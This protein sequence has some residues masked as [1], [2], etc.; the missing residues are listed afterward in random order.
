MRD[1]PFGICT[2]KNG[3]CLTTKMIWLCLKM[4]LYPATHGIFWLNCGKRWSVDGF[5]VFPRVFQKCSGC[6]TP[7]GWGVCFWLYFPMSWGWSLVPYLG[8]KID[9]EF[10]DILFF[11][12]FSGDQNGETLTGTSEDL[13][14]SNPPYIPT[15]SEAAGKLSP[16]SGGSSWRFSGVKGGSLGNPWTKVL[17]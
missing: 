5:F 8:T 14:V 13:I 16:H 4:E 9:T 17:V 1:L 12:F 6:S 2:C 11:L 15:K 3:I 7:L 10:C